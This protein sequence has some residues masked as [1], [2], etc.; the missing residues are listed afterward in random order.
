MN[1]MRFQWRNSWIS[2]VLLVLLFATYSSMANDFWKME[3]LY[4]NS[5]AHWDFEN[6]STIAPDILGGFCQ[7]EGIHGED[8]IAALLKQEAGDRSK[9]PKITLSTYGSSNCPTDPLACE[10]GF[11]VAFWLSLKS[12]TSSEVE[13][14][15][16]CMLL[17]LNDTSSDG[18]Q[19]MFN[20]DNNAVSFHAVGRR[21]QSLEAFNATH[22][23]MWNHLGMTWDNQTSTLKMYVNG[24]LSENVSMA[25]SPIVSPGEPLASEGCV[26]TAFD[27][28]AIWTR[29]LSEK[30]M[31]ILRIDRLNETEMMTTTQQETTLEET[32]PDPTT[33]A[34]TT[35][36][37]TTASPTTTALT[38][39][40]EKTTASPTTTQS[41]TTEK[42][43]SSPT[44]AQSSITE[45]AT[46]AHTMTE[47]PSTEKTTTSHPTT[48]TSTMKQTTVPTTESTFEGTSTTTRNATEGVT[49]SETTPSD[50]TLE[51]AV[52][53]VEGAN[54]AMEVV[55]G[56]QLVGSYLTD[57]G[58]PSDDMIQK[59]RKNIQ[60]ILDAMPPKMETLKNSS[61]T[62]MVLE[63][64]MGIVN[65]V[66]SINKQYA[67]EH[68]MLLS[69]VDLAFAVDSMLSAY[70]NT[71]SKGEKVIRNTYVDTTLSESVGTGSDI[72]MK[73]QQGCDSSCN[74]YD[75]VVV[76]PSGVF[77][78]SQTNKQASA[79]IFYEGVKDHLPKNITGDKTEYQV[80]SFL[81]GVN[82]NVPTPSELSV[83]ITVTIS[84]SKL[85][86]TQ[87]AKC[88]FLDSSGGWSTVGVSSI[89]E[90][91]NKTVI[92]TSNHLT[93]FAVLVSTRQLDISVVDK[94]ALEILTNVGLAIS[95]TCL[96]L[97]LII[98]NVLRQLNST[99]ISILK[100][101]AAALLI[102][103]IMFIVGASNLNQVDG[104]CTAVAAML[105]YFFLSTFCWMLIQ[106]VQLYM[107]VRRALKG[108]I[109]MVYFYVFGWGFPAIVVAISVGVSHT[110]YKNA[111]GVCWISLEHGVGTLIAFIGPAYLI[112]VI[113]L[114]VIFMVM[115]VF[116]TVKVNKDKSEMDKLKSGFKAVIVMVP[117]LGVTWFFGL[118]IIV[119]P[120]LVF[121]YLFVIFNTSQGLLM[122]LFHV[123]FND[124][125]KQAIVK[126]R[127]KIAAS[128]DSHSIFSRALKSKSGT[129]Q[130]TTEGF[131]GTYKSRKS[132]RPAFTVPSRF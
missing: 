55:E 96:I 22:T 23:W 61:E 84:I 26:Y 92:C 28:I 9:S 34:E 44:T 95:I 30:D 123:V 21:M 2:P 27:N 90:K 63:E 111:S 99:R 113:N 109:D 39:T 131:E 88:A 97:T 54:S 105:H 114:V 124:E 42:T 3:E 129:D 20:A 86:A 6:D 25:D 36:M 31:L 121:L 62:E 13:D 57:Y 12:S 91:D 89:T 41:S 120:D 18:F 51:D 101:T 108:N 60:S 122:F 40:A 125:V 29:P 107:K 76:I 100:H 7:I 53:K 8:S 10:D 103:Q 52:N 106:G 58:N 65:D 98:L 81:V 78:D 126:K 14:D 83:D 35:P 77:E 56:L 15:S 32:T 64:Y 11:T 118:F 48:G 69:G 16:N 79:S 43:T 87:E 80:A 119:S 19:V 37:E 104:L 59:D 46:T 112:L 127:N 117:I 71:V 72:V 115:H 17:S 110:N 38:S 70:I 116:L 4:N 94:V 1:T 33:E 93:N 67:S 74:D 49:A 50:L 47:S 73:L 75:I 66:L 132:P 5:L 128:K 82:L 130:T 85:N 68:K 24:E 102:A 45:K